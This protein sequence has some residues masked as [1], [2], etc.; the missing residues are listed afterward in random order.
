MNTKWSRLEAAEKLEVL[1][2]EKYDHDFYMTTKS[3]GDYLESMGCFTEP[4]SFFKVVDPDS[5]FKPG[6]LS[7]VCIPEEV[8]FKVLVLGG[9]P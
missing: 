1:L 7:F 4:D 6:G 2:S 8:A 3:C 5:F 9:F